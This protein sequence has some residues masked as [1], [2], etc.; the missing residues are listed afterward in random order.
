MSKNT[1]KK[2]RKNWRD[3]NRDFNT[4]KKR[5]LDL[6]HQEDVFIINCVRDGRDAVAGWDKAWGV[7]NPFVWMQSI[8][9][10]KAYESRIGMTIRYEDLLDNPLEV[11]M[12][13]ASELTIDSKDLFWHYPDF[14]PEECFQDKGTNHHLRLLEAYKPSK[15][16]VY[17][18]PPNN[19]QYFEYLLKELGYVWD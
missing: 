17:K 13:I 3:I 16:E 11:Q 12:R 18:K 8:M 4:E 19:V 1:S 9:D 2:D 14:V 15:S 5:Q 6:L 7:Y 10:S